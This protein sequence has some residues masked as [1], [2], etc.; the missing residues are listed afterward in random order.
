MSL[1]VVGTAAIIKCSF[2]MA[3]TPFVV[4]PERTVKAELMLMGNIM[5]MEPFKN[6]EPFGLCTSPL[7]PEVIAA[8]GAPMPCVPAPIT[9]WMSAAL[10]VLVQGS[11]AIDQTAMLMCTW[12]GVINVMEPGNF[13]VKVP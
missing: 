10:N 11:P 2:G 9:P 8:E 12:A 5:D 13:S 7:N 1:A 3:P 6:I 4:T